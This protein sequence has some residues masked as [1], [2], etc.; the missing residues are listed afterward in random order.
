MIK[1]IREEI[2]LTQEQFSKAFHFNLRTLQNWESGRSK[3]PEHVIFM[4]TKIIHQEQFEQ[5]HLGLK[6]FWSV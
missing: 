1:E 2:G 4:L 3:E 6:P 5:N